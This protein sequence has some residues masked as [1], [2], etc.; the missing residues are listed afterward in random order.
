MVCSSF[1]DVPL[2]LSPRYEASQ[3]SRITAIL[4]VTLDIYN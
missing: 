2:A 3:I 4:E 1:A